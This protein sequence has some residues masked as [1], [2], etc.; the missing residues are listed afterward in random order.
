MTSELL[1][2]NLWKVTL[3][4]LRVAY[5]YVTN[6]VYFKGCGKIDTTSAC[7]ML[8]PDLGQYL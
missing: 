5:Q 4:P 6:I 3:E 1:Q 8:K 7:Q 2:K